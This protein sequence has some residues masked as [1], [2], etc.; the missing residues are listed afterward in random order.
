[1]NDWKDFRLF[2][3][4]MIFS[5]TLGLWIG[6]IKAH[7]EVS[8]ECQRLGKFYVGSNTYECSIIPDAK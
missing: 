5:G 2:V 3:L 8:T 4:W 6:W 7:H 1:M